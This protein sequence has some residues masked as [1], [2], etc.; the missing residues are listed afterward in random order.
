MW[1]TSD[2]CYMT[3][4]TRLWRRRTV[5]KNSNNRFVSAELG[6]PCLSD[7]VVGDAFI[8]HHTHDAL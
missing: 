3:V 8:R 2:K 1:K 4:E 5:Q 6:F 7:A